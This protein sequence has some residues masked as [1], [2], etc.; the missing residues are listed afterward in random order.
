MTPFLDSTFKC[1]GEKPRHDMF[2][3]NSVREIKIL[4]LKEVFKDSQFTLAIKLKLRQV[5][6]DFCSD[7]KINLL[8]KT[9]QDYDLGK[10][11]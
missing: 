11:H 1:E 2:T 7:G 10:S 5:M 4:E 8:Q 9:S 6:N 3:M